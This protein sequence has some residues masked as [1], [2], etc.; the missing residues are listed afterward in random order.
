MQD[1][2]GQKSRKKNNAEIFFISFF[3]Q[4]LHFTVLSIQATREAFCPQKRT[5]KTSKDERH[6]LGHFR[7]PQR[8]YQ[9]RK[10]VE[11]CHILAVLNRYGSLMSSLPYRY[12]RYRYKNLATSPLLRGRFQTAIALWA[13]FNATVGIVI[14]C[15]KCSSFPHVTNVFQE[16]YFVYRYL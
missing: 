8:C 6:Q 12:R 4:R 2:D 9:Y 1:F 11:L 7:D 14:I 15:L 13:N 5:N 3:D 10:R 16:A